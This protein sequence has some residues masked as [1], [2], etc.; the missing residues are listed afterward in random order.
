VND[1]SY[2]KDYLDWLSL[3]YSELTYKL[4]ITSPSAWAEEHRYL[5]AAV[6]PLPGFYSYNVSPALKE[7]VDCMDV[8]STI[9]EVTLMKGAQIG[10]TVGVLEN[11][12]GYFISQVKNAP[13]ML[14]TADA[15]LAKTRMDGHITVMIQQSGL[16]G[17]IKSSDELS[18][19]KTGKT[20]QKIEWIGGGYLLPFGARNAAKLRS[21]PIQVLLEDEIDG[22]PEVVGKDG[23]PMKLAEGRTKAYSQTRKIL[24]LSTPLIKGAS[25][26]E[27]A[28]SEGDQRRYH[29][30]CKKC[31]KLQELKFSGKNEETGEVWGLVWETDDN[32]ILI[33]ESVKYACQF[34]GH[35]HSNSDKTWMLPRGK[36]IATAKPQ[37]P[38]IRSYHLN[39]LYSPAAMYPWDEAVRDWLNCWDIEENRVK[40]LGLMQEFY[41]NV[42]GKTFELRGTKLKFVTVS[43]HRRNDYR[44]GEIPNHYAEEHSGGKILVLT[45]A[46][47]V[48]KDNLSVTVFG[49]TRG[50]R[51]YLIDY[52]K[53]EGDTSQENDLGTWKRLSTLIEGD[54]YVADDGSMYRITMTLIDSGYLP[55]QVYRFCEQYENGVF[56]I[57]GRDTPTKNAAIKEFSML[58][59]PFGTNLYGLTVNFYKDRMS[60]VLSKK[61]DGIGLQSERS[62][63][64]PTDITDAQLKELTVEQKREKINKV[65]KKR[66]GFEWYRPGGAKNELWD[67]LIYNSAAIDII[68]L[69]VCQA[70]LGLDHVSWVAFWDYL[71]NEKIFYTPI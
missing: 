3:S 53:F 19:N 25:R 13:M 26:I 1:D 46:V 70:Y 69:N 49:W 10:A 39:A 52:W 47:D 9:R 61:W 21:N 31:K 11:T 6:S 62:F 51:S 23:D 44:F 57:K 29:V 37:T 67:L 32:G 55:D 48:H 17:Q 68:A 35:L 56:P 30:P 27:R 4:K 58:K 8:R 12:I 24:R 18:K 36:W 20:N 63:N 16:T 22:Y 65:T 34:C 50:C 38:N 33:P 43:N 15:E 59:S 28:Y 54:G 41:N 66:E 71:E 60:A 5:P 2:N 40:D 64:V 14:L 7:I 45:C 42:L